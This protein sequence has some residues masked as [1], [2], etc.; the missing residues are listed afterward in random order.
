MSASLRFRAARALLR[1]VLGT[2]LRV[3]MEGSERLPKHAYVLACNHL[4]W[5]DPFLLIAWLP[6]A[7]RLHFLGRRSA[8]Y[9]RLW[10]RWILTF[11]GGVIPIESGHLRPLSQ[12][13][14]GVLRRGGAVA[15]F[16]EGGVGSVEGALQP[17]RPGVG[18]FA[19]D[20]GVPVLAV[21]LAGTYELWRGKRIRIRVGATVE[22]SGA[23]DGDMTAIEAAMREALPP[24]SEPGGRRPWPWMTTLLR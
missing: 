5:V 12:A 15:I 17:L 6:A 23:L 3:E 16:P 20:N 22:P 10:K 11:L 1:L 9:N 19:A 8:I 4:N 14:T 18:H 13:V 21:G 7:P 2:V 24:Y